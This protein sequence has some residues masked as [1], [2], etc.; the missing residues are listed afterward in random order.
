MSVSDCFSRDYAEARARFRE[1][2][3]RVAAPVSSQLLPGL[4]GPGGEELATDVVCLGDPQAENA[5]LVISGTHGV[6][7]FAGSGCQV[8][9]L[10][11]GFADALTPGVRM[12]LLH[13]LN[14]HGFAWLRRVNEDGVDINRNFADFGSLPS[15]AAYEE[16]HD[17]LVPARWDEAHCRAADARLADYIAAHGMRAYQTAVTAGQ[18]TRPTGL[19]YGG[20]APTWSARTLRSLLQQQLGG[21]K[22]LAV[23]DIHTGLGPRG[24]G[25]PIGLGRSPEDHAR[26]LRLYGGDVRDLSGGESVSAVVGGSVADGVYA[27]L[28][29]A[30]ITYVALEF[31]TYPMDVVLE[32]LRRDHSCHA[33]NT[34][35]PAEAAACGRRM[36]DAAYIETP[37]WQAAVFGRTADFAY[38]A[39]RVLGE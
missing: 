10:E 31:G 23:L 6:E 5:L 27:A 37:A 24:Y 14:P 7:G 21:V 4:H 26:A 25:E 28:P 18:Y 30:E 29:Q 2:A 17:A 15:S 3:R 22:R 11:N 32:A 8:G 1:A 20:T 16:L 19:F 33:S 36:R 13:A 38:R 9:L 35:D 34:P 12:V 39:L